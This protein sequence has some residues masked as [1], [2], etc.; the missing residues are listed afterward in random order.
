MPLLP[1][2]VDIWIAHI[3]DAAVLG[4]PNTSLDGILAPEERERRSRLRFGSDRKLFTMAHALL[5]MALARYAPV[6]PS[7]W[8]FTRGAY[9]KPALRADQMQMHRLYFSLSHAGTAVTCAV[10]H[11]ADVGVDIEPLD[12]AVDPCEL[13]ASVLSPAEQASLSAL[14]NGARRQ[15]FLA[16]WTLK[17]AYVK[18]R[19]LGLSFP[20]QD[21]SFSL[22][23]LQIAFAGPVVDDPDDWQ[24]DSQLVDNG[25]IIAAAA[26]LGSARPLR[27]RYRYSRDCQS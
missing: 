19:G 4:V 8:T 27:F 25:H 22:D 12:N 15:R 11:A 1:D 26:H 21:C 5:R 18:A 9:G 7:A 23:P 10:C 3:D 14:E 2:T 17:E 6:L 24:F 20:L 16:L 13:A